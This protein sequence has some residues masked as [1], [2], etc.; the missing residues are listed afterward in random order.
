[1]QIISNY[2]NIWN[3]CLDAILKLLDDKGCILEL[4]GKRTFL[5]ITDLILLGYGAKYW[6]ESRNTLRPDVL[7][8]NLFCP[9]LSHPDNLSQY[10]TQ[11]GSMGE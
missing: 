6:P 7:F 10:T 3:S 2:G 8:L 5:D 4:K 1:M 11:D 9:N